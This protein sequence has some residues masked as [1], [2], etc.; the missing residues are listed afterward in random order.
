[1]CPNRSRSTQ[2]SK[3]TG[4]VHV[5][6][7]S[8]VDYFEYFRCFK[9]LRRLRTQIRQDSLPLRLQLD[10]EQVQGG[11]EHLSCWLSKRHT[12]CRRWQVAFGGPLTYPASVRP[13][14]ASNVLQMLFW[15]E[16]TA[17]RT[18]AKC[19]NPHWWFSSYRTTCV[20]SRGSSVGAVSD[21]GLDGRGS[22]LD[23]G[24]GFFL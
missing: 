8:K 3:W 11:V 10:S 18:C 6:Q 13:A 4:C 7:R 2:S 17:Q 15:R 5:V 23:R 21:Y 19:L 14:K 9:F 12:R 20:V 1:V 22:I 24:R 16:V